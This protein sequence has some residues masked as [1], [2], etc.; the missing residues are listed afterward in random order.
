M[1]ELRGPLR[2]IDGYSHALIEDYGALLD[3]HARDYIMRTRT[4]SQR[5]GQII[6][7]MLTLSRT[8]RRELVMAETDLSALA[9][10]ALMRLALDDPGRRVETE[11]VEGIRAHGDASLLAIVL[12]N[13]L[14]NAWK[15][16]ARVEA[17]RIGF[18]DLRQEGQTVYWVRDNGVG[19]DMT[20]IDK[21]FQPFQRLHSAEDYPGSG[22][23]LATAARIIHR[24]GGR[25]WAQSEVG[26]GA[27]F[28]FTLGT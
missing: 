23:G 15:Y 25:I 1:E 5:M 26:Q 14:S 22:I 11:V 18:G 19:F 10:D 20:Y 12:D 17:A 2:A 4:A 27:T 24:H 21:L 28:Y 3:E 8:T 9:R 16:T 7:D 6:D 13:L